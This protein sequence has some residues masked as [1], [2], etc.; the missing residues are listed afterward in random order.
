MPLLGTYSKD[1]KAPALFTRAKMWNQPSC[2]S[3]N[4]WVKNTSCSAI[5]K[6]MEKFG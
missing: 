4:E 3:A 1:S 5:K 2:P 6:Q